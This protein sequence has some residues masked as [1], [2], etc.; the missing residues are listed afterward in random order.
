MLVGIR[1][2]CQCHI[3]SQS[4]PCVM[5]HTA[6]ELEE[7]LS[8]TVATSAVELC[9]AL[10]CGL[11][12]DCK[13]V[14]LLLVTRMAKKLKP[15]DFLAVT[16]CC[17]QNHHAAVS[18]HLSPKFMSKI[19]CCIFSPPKWLGPPDLPPKTSG[20]HVWVLLLA[21]ALSTQQNINKGGRTQRSGPRTPCTSEPAQHCMQWVSV[22]LKCNFCS[23]GGLGLSWCDAEVPAAHANITQIVASHSALMT[24][25]LHKNFLFLHCSHPP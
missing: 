25:Q 19:L 3:I 16:T 21:Q 5:A 18:P 9:G 8:K 6:S 10:V 1:D 20:P 14:S 15:A 2:Q 7:A 4:A 12:S 24:F 13:K 17:G 11:K 23:A 22:K